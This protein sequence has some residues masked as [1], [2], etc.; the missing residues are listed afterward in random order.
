MIWRHYQTKY[1]FSAA[2]FKFLKVVFWILSGRLKAESWYLN[3]TDQKWIVSSLML[4]SFTGY[5]FTADLGSNERTWLAPMCPMMLWTLSHRHF[6]PV[7]KHLK[8]LFAGSSTSNQSIFEILI[9]VK[10]TEITSSFYSSHM[11]LYRC[12]W[13]V[14]RGQGSQ[15]AVREK[16]EEEAEKSLHG[17]DAR[18]FREDQYDSHTDRQTDSLSLYH[19]S[20]PSSSSSLGSFCFLFFSSICRHSSRKKKTTLGAKKQVSLFTYSL[21][22]WAC[23]CVWVYVCVLYICVCV[24]VL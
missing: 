24:C 3:I 6:L 10:P 16:E 15:P 21:Q 5:R 22:V 2:S 1:L 13:N 4:N 17:N 12:F 18:V 19:V 23:V 9:G 14:F 20:L 8:K 7:D 11:M